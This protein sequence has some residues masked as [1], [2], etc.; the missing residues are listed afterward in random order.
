MAEVARAPLARIE[1]EKERKGWTFPFYS[2]P[3]GDFND[4]F[5][6]TLAAPRGAVEY[7]YRDATTGPGP[8]QGYQ[9]DPPARSVFLRDGDDV[10]HA[11]SAY[12]RGLDL[13]ATHYNYLDL[14]PYGRQE[15]WEDSPDGWPQAPTYG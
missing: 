13:L 5:Q 9:G 10:F 15:D 11:Y 14:T 8:L 12:T 2:S 1:R 4:D 6:A 7:N 3:G